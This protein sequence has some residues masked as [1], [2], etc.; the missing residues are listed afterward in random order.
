MPAFPVVHR[1]AGKFPALPNH[2]NAFLV[3]L[4]HASVVID[5]TIALSSA[6]QL[7]AIAEKVG[8]PIR[9]V[10]MTHGHPDH[11]SGLKVFEDVPRY[12]SQG[13]LDFSRKEDAEKGALGKSYHGDDFAEP[14]VFPN[15]IVKG[16][17]TLTIDGTAFAFSD[18]GP[19]ESDADGMWVVRGASGTHAFI[20]DL[21]AKDCHS[22]FRDGHLREW[23]KLLDRLETT[24]PA[25]VFLYYGH[26][27]PGGME[28]L[29]WQR[30]Y[31]QAFLD[32]IRAIPEKDRLPSEA[33]QASVIAAMQ[34]HMP[35]DA[36]IFLLTYDL[37]HVIECY[38]RKY[39]MA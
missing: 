21:V 11:F 22:F 5:A 30:G 12:A 25:D 2:V 39:G 16:G 14:R 7:V 34:K 9:A 8:K 32:A 31:N 29:R 38:W 20:G 17:T 35:G 10:L 37:P 36:A 4:E 26:G 28:Q 6:R 13:C 3:E 1:V 18:L 15:M 23:M 33:D 19:G 27:E 24:L